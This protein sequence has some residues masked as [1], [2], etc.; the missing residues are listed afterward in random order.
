MMIEG[1]L[2]GLPLSETM[3]DEI[4]IRDDKDAYT[5]DFVQLLKDYYLHL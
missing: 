5:P 3:I 2:K 4:S 1:Q